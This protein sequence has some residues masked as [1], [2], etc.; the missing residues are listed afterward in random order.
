MNSPAAE[1]CIFIRLTF[2]LLLGLLLSLFLHRFFRSGALIYS[3]IFL[4]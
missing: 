2:A 3:M 4:Q 1:T